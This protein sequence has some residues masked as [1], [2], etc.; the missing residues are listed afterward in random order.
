MKKLI[1]LAVLVLLA[2]SAYSAFA[3]SSVT[4]TVTYEVAAINEIS[5]SSS[6]VSLTVNA[7][8]AGSA[9]NDATDASTTYAI[10]TNGT[11]MKISGKINTAMPSGTSLKVSLVAPTG[12][13][14]NG[15]TTLG[16]TDAILVSG[17]TKLAESSKT[18]T[19]TLSATLAAGVVASASKTVTLTVAQGV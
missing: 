9:P 14:S 13:T 11:L 19:Y 17:I 3:G 2:G 7:A 4:Q 1:G 18:I 12:G 8:T 16:T 6:S 15:T 10:T 5:V